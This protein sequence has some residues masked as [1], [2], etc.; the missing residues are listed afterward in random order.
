MA[1]KVEAALTKLLAYLQRTTGVCPFWL[2]AFD[3]AP[4]FT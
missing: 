3:R 2:A 1:E 4:L